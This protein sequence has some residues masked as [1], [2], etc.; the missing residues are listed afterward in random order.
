MPIQESD[1]HLGLYKV[2]VEDSGAVTYSCLLLASL[3]PH[4]SLSFVM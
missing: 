1:H 3:V 2:G 4:F